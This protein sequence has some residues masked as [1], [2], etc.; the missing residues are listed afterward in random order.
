MT[1]Y[2]IYDTNTGRALRH[3]KSNFPLLK[4]GPGESVFIGGAYGESIR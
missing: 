1:E 3:G 2:T 4:A